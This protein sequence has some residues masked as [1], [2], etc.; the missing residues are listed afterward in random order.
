M[1]AL[2]LGLLL[3]SCGREHDFG[4]VL[5]APPGGALANGDQVSVVRLSEESGKA[6][7]RA[8]QVKGVV[9][10]EAWRLRLASSRDQLRAQAEAYAPYVSTFAYAQRD[11]LPLREDPEQEARR[12]YKLREGQVLKV[13][14][15]G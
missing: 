5:W 8:R 11:G 14:S 9:E 15:R 2:L 7:V 6:T 3:A 1:G 10:L 13:L 4:V 12:V